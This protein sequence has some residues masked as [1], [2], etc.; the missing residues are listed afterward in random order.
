MKQSI[1]SN[2][3]NVMLAEPVLVLIGQS[4][5]SKGTQVTLLLKT[6]KNLRIKPF[7]IETGEL[8]RTEIKKF[9]TLN[10]EK[11]SEIQN[12]GK[13]QSHVHATALWAHELLYNYDSGP[14]IFDGSPRSIPEADDMLSFLIKYLGKKVIFIIL[15]VSDEEANR[16][17][18]ER[19]NSLIGN[20]KTV[21]PE[22]DSPEKIAE[23]LKFFHTHVKP[24]IDF[25]K[26]HQIVE[27]NVHIINIETEKKNKSDVHNDIIT[28]ISK[29][30]L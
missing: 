7:T 30:T 18:I 24:A 25:V 13:I 21:R 23:K 28:A 29:L 3:I 11:I 16:R 19:H 20:G 6:C 22:T 9:S 17:I 15:N 12:S 1:I 10:K 4:G 14:I 26:N 5:S 27:N 2:F 8:F